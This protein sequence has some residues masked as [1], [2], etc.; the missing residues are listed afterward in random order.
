MV[1]PQ[2][3]N[4]LQNRPGLFFSSYSSYAIKA[5]LDGY[6]FGCPNEELQSF[7]TGFHEFISNKWKVIPPVTWDSAIRLYTLSDYQAFMLFF[8]LIDEYVDNCTPLE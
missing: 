5:F 6:L 8:E 1:K 4:S 3:I 7:L 2:I